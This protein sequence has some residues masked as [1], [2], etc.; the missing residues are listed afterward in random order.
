MDKF[1]IPIFKSL[2]FL[3][4]EAKGPV[5]IGSVILPDERTVSLKVNKKHKVA[6]MLV[7]G[8]KEATTSEELSP[9]LSIHLGVDSGKLCGI[10]I[11]G[12]GEFI[13]DWRDSGGINSMLPAL[14]RFSGKY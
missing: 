13:Q 4:E 11:V 12:I 7:E 14:R 2:V 8:L 1:I 9:L 10:T 5:A 6:S 3:Y